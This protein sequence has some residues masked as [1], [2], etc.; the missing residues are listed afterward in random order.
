MVATSMEVPIEDIA[1]TVEGDLDLSGT[2]ALV[3]DAPV[4]FTAIRVRFD[5]TAPD[6]SKEQLDALIEKT[7]RYGV[8]LQTLTAPPV[9]E[10]RVVA[11]A[12]A[13]A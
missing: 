11:G 6:A 5:L 13:S 10:T 9:I 7:E 1:V 8:V 2:L 12:R 3:R 4:G